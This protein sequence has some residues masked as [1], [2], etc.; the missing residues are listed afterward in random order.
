MAHA[1]ALRH[2]SERF[3]TPG[4]TSELALSPASRQ[5]LLAMRR[6]HCRAMSQA[7]S[8]LTTLLRPVLGS[9][10]KVSRDA[11]ISLPLFQSAQQVQRL[12]MD[13]VFGPVS[14]NESE[15]REAAEAAQGLISTLQGL[16][17]TLEE[18]P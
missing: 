3:G 17:I 7:T 9:M 13:L 1:W 2:L 6:D 18:Q 5:L 16:E 12:T 10:V 8:E 11:G 4:V 14:P 15:N